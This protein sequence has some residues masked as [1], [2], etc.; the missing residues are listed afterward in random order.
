MTKVN[1]DPIILPPGSID[2]D[3]LSAALK[4]GKSHEEAIEAGTKD[5]PK[6]EEVDMEK[7]EAERLAALQPVEEASATT[8]EVAKPAATASAKE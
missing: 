2:F 7:V 4:A 1:E 3:K 8:K 5:N 6:P